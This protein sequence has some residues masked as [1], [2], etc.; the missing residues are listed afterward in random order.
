MNQPGDAGVINT[1]IKKAIPNIAT[2]SSKFK[3]LMRQVRYIVKI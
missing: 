1:I 3:R 2:K